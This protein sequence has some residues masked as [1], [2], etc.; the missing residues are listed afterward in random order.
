MNLPRGRGILLQKLVRTVAARGNWRFI[1]V[2]I[3]TCHWT[4]PQVNSI[5]T[6]P[7]FHL[8]FIITFFILSTSGSSEWSLSYTFHS[9]KSV[10]ISEL[11]NAWYWVWKVNCSFCHYAKPFQ[12]TSYLRSVFIS[13]I[14]SILSFHQ[15]ICLT[16]CR[17]IISYPQ[18]FYICFCFSQSS[19]MSIPS[20]CPSHLHVIR[21]KLDVCSNTT[22]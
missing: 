15:R 11:Y 14:M 3:L 12:S 2:F 20:T 4:N 7:P 10:C 1:A 17:S 13:E 5:P 8:R 6:L 22:K 16:S 9:G 21:V 19:H 18:K